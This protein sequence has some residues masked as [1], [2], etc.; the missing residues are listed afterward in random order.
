MGALFS[1]LGRTLLR[2]LLRPLAR[3]VVGIIAIPL[4]RLFMRRV[5]RLQ[6]L[7]AEL[8]KDLEQWFR[9]SLVLLVATRNM[10]EPLFGWVPFVQED[11]TNYILMGLRIMLAVGVVEMMPDQ[12]LFSII[13]PGPPGVSLRKDVF[14]QVWRKRWLFFKGLICKHLARSSPVFAILAAIADGTVGW[15]CYTLAIAQ[16]L[17]I[18]LVTSRDKALDALSE[19]DRQVAKRR[20]ELVEEFD[21]REGEEH[22]PQSPAEPNA[23]AGEADG[24]VANRADAEYFSK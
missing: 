3:F 1:Y 13:H 8:E 5:I 10:E 15:I 14:R 16:Y 21:V 11:Q 19:F 7:D 12:E 24:D 6:E 23:Q 18:G 20:R 17:I 22:P 2:P 4:F 9:G